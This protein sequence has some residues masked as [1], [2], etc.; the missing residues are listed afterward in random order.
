MHLPGG[1]AAG[2]TLCPCPIIVLL[3]DGTDVGCCSLQ[4]HFDMNAL[5]GSESQDRKRELRATS[6][7]TKHQATITARAAAP[8]SSDSRLSYF[9]FSLEC[10]ACEVE[11]V[12]EVAEP[13]RN[14]ACSFPLAGPFQAVRTEDGNKESKGEGQGREQ[15]K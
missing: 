4:F 3:F 8:N 7:C 1:S 12:P 13:C 6:G 9:R 2:K 15:E 10:S 5:I 14:R 11:D